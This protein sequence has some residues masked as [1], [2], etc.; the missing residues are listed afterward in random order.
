MGENNKKLGQKWKYLC[1]DIKKYKSAKILK[2]EVGTFLP[3]EPNSTCMAKS[4]VGGSSYRT[5]HR[6]GACL[7]GRTLCARFSSASAV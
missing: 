6:H 1:Y 3:S 4:R 7:L 2:M 5:S